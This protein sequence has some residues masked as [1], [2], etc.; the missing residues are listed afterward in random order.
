M[1]SP[2]TFQSSLAILKRLKVVNN[3][4]ERGVTLVQAYN[5]LLTKDE[6][7]LQ[8]LLQ[9]VSEHGRVYPDIH[10]ETLCQPRQ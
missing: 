2:E 1:R 9:V 7:R 10:K 6:E 3:N 8:F 5:R 4:D